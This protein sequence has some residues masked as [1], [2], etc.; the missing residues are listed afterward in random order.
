MKAL[1]WDDDGKPS[2]ILFVLKWGGE[3]TP[4]GLRV[5]EDAGIEFRNSM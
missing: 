2:E 5:A 4:S 3:I 1:K